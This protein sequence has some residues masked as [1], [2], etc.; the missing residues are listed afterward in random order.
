MGPQEDALVE[1]DAELRDLST[2]VDR[3]L[4][5]EGNLVVISGEAGMGK[6]SLL[7]SVRDQASTR[8]Y[9]TLPAGGS[10][11]E[12]E[13]PFGLVR[14][15][16]G[17]VVSGRRAGL[18]GR[19]L[20]DAAHLADPLFEATGRGV[21]VGTDAE[22]FPLLHG[23]FWLASDVAERHPL[24]LCIDDLHWVDRASL[25]FVHYLS[26]RLAELP[27]VVATTLRSGEAATDPEGVERLSRHPAASRIVLR[28]L[29]EEG[30][31]TLVRR[32][33][34]D[35]EPALARACS[36][37]TGGNPF[38]L[39][40]LLAWLELDAVG[41]TPSAE[42]L[43]AIERFSFPCGGPARL[44]AP[45]PASGP[46]GR[47]RGRGGGPRRQRRGV[48]PGGAQRPRCDR[49]GASQR[50][51]GGGRPPGPGAPDPLCPSPPAL[52]RLRRDRARDPV[53][54]APPGGTNPRGRWSTR[55]PCRVT[56]PRVHF[57]R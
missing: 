56:A 36:A 44:R 29:S 42:S 47:A 18:D 45:Q 13:F 52:G 30:V 19:P 4:A 17:P 14:S 6:S 24:L 11:F 25:R 55:G 27:I 53:R 39:R 5:G 10:E 46:G 3:G 28:A 43:A 9:V 41:G 32:A 1:R 7:A 51:P 50:S 23:L 15:L 38:L 54:R 31:Q 49:H 33:F 34:P 37:A 20:S 2:A 48:A 22:I 12:R 35:A 21:G 40:E 16:F 57:R 8:G 26:Q